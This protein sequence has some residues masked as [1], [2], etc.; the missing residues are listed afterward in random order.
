MRGT[1]CVVGVDVDKDGYSIEQGDCDDCDER[2]NPGAVDVPSG[3]DEN[4]DGVVDETPLP[5]DG[6][7][8]LDDASAVHA[9]EAIGICSFLAGAAW[10][11]PDGAPP[12]AG[13]AELSAFHLGHGLLDSFGPFAPVQEGERVL[14]LS[15][16]T[17]RRATDPGFV[18]RDFDKGYGCNAPAGFPTPSDSC[19]G[20]VPLEA[21]DGTALQVTLH[22]P[23]N[24][25]GFSFDFAFFSYA[26]PDD[27]CSGFDDAFAALLDPPPPNQPNAN[28]A[29]DT[30]LEPVTVNGA[31]FAECGCPAGP[32]CLA[33]P[34][35]APQKAFDCALGTAL[36]EGT[37]FDG[38]ASTTAGWTNGGTGW[39][40]SKAVVVPNETFTVRFAVY[41]AG[42]GMA[43]SAVL[44]D[45]WIWDGDEG[46]SGPDL[47]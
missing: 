14:M 7:L 46:D 25:K 26:W 10:V 42:D 6:G 27:V 43:D 17:A 41:D 30:N 37:D 31:L 24:A 23:T 47:P 4:C 36:L 33:P 3:V 1:P 16:G 29:F 11:L 19:P 32:P 22:A 35:G 39:R 15:S 38:T 45:N 18:S 5:C 2:V 21:R 12:P 8:A 34:S 28:I 44:I 40:R 13:S 9:A 20:V